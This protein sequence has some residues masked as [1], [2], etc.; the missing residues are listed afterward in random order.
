MK[1]LNR[2]IAVKPAATFLII[3]ELKYHSGLILGRSLII[4]FIQTHIYIYIYI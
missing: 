1:A 2:Q 4:C 3:E